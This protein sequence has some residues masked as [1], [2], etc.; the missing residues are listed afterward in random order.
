MPI[1]KKMKSFCSVLY[2]NGFEIFCIEKIFI[3]RWSEFGIID[4]KQPE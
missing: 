4:A 2:F 3:L 1:L